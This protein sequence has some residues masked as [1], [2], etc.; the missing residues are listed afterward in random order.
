ERSSRSWA[1]L[2]VIARPPG[3]GH[4][5]VEA[6]AVALG[7]HAERAAE[8]DTHRFGTAEPA[9]G[10]DVRDAARRLLEQPPRRFDADPLDEA[11]GCHPDL[12]HEDAKRNSAGS[13]RRDARARRPTDRARGGRGST[14]ADR[15]G[16]RAPPSGS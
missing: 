15:A 11:P 4:G 13:S 10:G 6:A 3:L 5:R 8:R 7:V 2:E 14:P 1:S 16:A 9:R 12:A